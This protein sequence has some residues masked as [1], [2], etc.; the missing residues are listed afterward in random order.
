MDDKQ[1]QLL[2]V[3]DEN[4]RVEL[5]IFHNAVKKT[6]KEYHESPTKKNKQNLDAARDSLESKKQE[7]N[8]KYFGQDEQ[9][10]GTPVFSSLLEV[11]KH[12]DKAGFRIS[13][14]KLYRDKDKAMIRV[15]PD[16]SVPET[17][18]RAYAST[19]E[20]KDG[21]IDD[22]SDIHAQK[23]KKEVEKLEEQIAKARFEREKEE[24][25]YIPKKDFEAELAAR[26]ATLD[27]GFRHLFNSRVREWV[28][29]VNGDV[30]KSADFLQDLNNSLN[31]LLNQYAVTDSFNVI[32]TG[33]E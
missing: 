8:Q 6:L 24:G 27:A 18:V 19:L 10:N 12:L 9:A 28:N 32:F 26:A 5:T 11:L 23:T 21:N 14:S 17:E 15:N 16:G 3:A 13:K 4:D 33:E 20:R 2:E 29:L 30:K 1:K 25:K 22:L 7:M 31:E